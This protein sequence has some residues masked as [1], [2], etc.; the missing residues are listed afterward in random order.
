MKT[1]FSVK[2][3]N[4]LKISLLENKPMKDKVDNSQEDWSR[5]KKVKIS[6]SNMKKGHHYIPY[7]YL[8]YIHNLKPS[9]KKSSDSDG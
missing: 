1:K 6:V 5:K 7:R 2:K 9:H 8:N 3:I 4:K